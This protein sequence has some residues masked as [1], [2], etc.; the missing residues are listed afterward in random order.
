MLKPYIPNSA[1]LICAGCGGGYDYRVMPDRSCP[2]CGC[3]PATIR[4]ESSDGERVSGSIVPNP[5]HAA[6]L[7][8]HPRGGKAEPGDAKAKASRAEYMKAYMAK[9]RAL[10][11]SGTG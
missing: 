6:W 8:A 3:P 4:V 7:T 11:R 5:E 10:E 1:L 2:E 9:R